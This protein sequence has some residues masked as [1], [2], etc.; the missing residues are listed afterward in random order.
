MH[1]ELNSSTGSKRQKEQ[2]K[3]WIL[4]QTRKETAKIKSKFDV[5]LRQVS[6]LRS[7]GLSN[8]SKRIVDRMASVLKLFYGVSQVWVSQSSV[9]NDLSSATRFFFDFKRT[10]M[11]F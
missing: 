6:V 10:G 5:V 4:E 9:S 3:Q 2:L 8:R 11:F 1:S 7:L